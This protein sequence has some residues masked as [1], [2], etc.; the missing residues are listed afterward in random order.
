[1]IQIAEILEC[2]KSQ[3]TK[4]AVQWISSFNDLLRGEDTIIDLARTVF[5]IDPT[6]LQLLIINYDNYSKSIYQFD[7]RDIN[8]HIMTFMNK[9]LDFL[10]S[11]INEDSDF[12]NVNA[13]NFF[14]SKLETENR[15]YEFLKNLSEKHEFVDTPF[16]WTNRIKNEILDEVSDE[17][18][19]IS[20]YGDTYKD[21]K[22]FIEVCQGFISMK[23]WD[24]EYIK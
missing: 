16:S 9:Q 10:K 7:Y 21:V 17:V 23:R 6:F 14:F 4:L 5:N 13:K 3:A 22:Y 24:V 20:K 12:L 1:M 18:S 15:E 8:M 19:N 2:H 11:K